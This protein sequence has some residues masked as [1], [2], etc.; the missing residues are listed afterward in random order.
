MLDKLIAVSLIIGI[1]AGWMAHGWYEGNQTADD[2]IAAAAAKTEKQAEQHAVTE[3]VVTEYVDRIVYV[4]GKTNEILKEVP[5]YIPADAMLPGGFRLLHDAAV[6]GELPESAGL[7]D[8]QPIDAQTAST[9]VA[10]NYGACHEVRERLIGLQ[11]W[12]R[13]QRE[14]G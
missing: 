5:V 6:R 10:E 4:K 7:A 12:V 14:G 13:A 3:K 11:Q 2:R 9:T 1:I 8:A